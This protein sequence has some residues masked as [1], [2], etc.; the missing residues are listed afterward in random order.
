MVDRGSPS[1]LC[2]SGW[3]FVRSGYPV[4]VRATA[5]DRR[6]RCRRGGA[7]RAD[8]R[9]PGGDGTE[10]G[11]GILR[12]ADRTSGTATVLTPVAVDRIHRVRIGIVFKDDML[13]D[14]PNGGNRERQRSSGA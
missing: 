6:G 5:P 12:H 14:P 1:C 10:H 7:A 13:A 3:W 9:D 4:P 8:V 2:V 11:L